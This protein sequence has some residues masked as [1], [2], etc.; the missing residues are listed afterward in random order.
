MSKELKRVTLVVLMMFGALFV[1]TSI[2]QYFQASTLAADGRNSRS[3][4]A[5]YDQQRG[6]ILVD[7]QPVAES[8]PSA[9]EYKFQRVY[10][11]GPLYS[12][13]TGYFTQGQGSSGI[14]QSLGNELAGTSDSQFLTRLNSIFTGKSPQ[15]AAV[16]TTIDPVIQQVAWDALGDLQGAVVAIEPATGRILT[17]VS[18]PTYDPNSLAVHDGQLVLDTYNQLLAASGDPLINRTIAGNLNPPGSTFKIVTSSAAI[19]NAGIAPTDSVP[20]LARFPLPDSTSTVSNAGGGTCGGG[21]TVTLQTAFALSCN[22]PMAEFGVQM[23]EKNL[24]D[25][26]NAFGFGRDLNIPMAVTPSTMDSGMGDARLALS[27]F[28]QWEDRVTPLQVAMFSAAV[29]NG[30]VLMTPTLID[31]ITA[32]DLTSIKSFSATEFA[33][34]ITPATSQTLSMFMVEAVKSGVAGNAAISGV[35]VAG[36]TGTAENG[37]GDPYTLWF[38]GF[39]PTENP[40]V[41]VAVLVE[42][43]GGK[44]QT[45]TGNSLAAPIAK[46]VI[47]A[48]LG[49]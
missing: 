48:V 7:G 15:G 36:K 34:P 4:Y 30:G 45:G 12:Q 49:K 19:Q 33:R 9:D 6:P 25:M 39:A 47:E 13:V 26:A 46:K 10:S 27:S 18:K 17:M 43:G 35:S 23:G 37:T 24:T 32:P 8:V 22:I 31:S 41:A 16:E 42:N 40:K 20:N 11:N 2:I 38:T 5:S 29:A 21:D 1:S 3:L 28:G 14:E 44:G